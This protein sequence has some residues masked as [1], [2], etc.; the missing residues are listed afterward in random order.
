MQ[1]KIAT[2]DVVI[3]DGVGDPLANRPS[4]MLPP[5][6][7][8]TNYTVTLRPKIDAPILESIHEKA[9][10]PNMETL[11]AHELGHFVAE[12]FGD[13]THNKAT[14]YLATLLGESSL[15]VPAE[16]RAW[17]IG[18]II[19]PKLN[20]NIRARALQGYASNGQEGA[21]R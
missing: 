6:N 17:E 7:G 5:G 21:L 2:L 18:E 4:G 15:I 16:K 20:R 9:N 3:S 14:K 19:N 13:P 11:L 8:R 10:I 1:T 12:V